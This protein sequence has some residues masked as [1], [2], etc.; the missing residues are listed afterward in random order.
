MKGVV[1]HDIVRRRTLK[2][3]SELL[4]QYGIYTLSASYAIVL[5]YIAY[6]KMYPKEY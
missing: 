3:K 6:R 4:S 1:R 5:M 2:K